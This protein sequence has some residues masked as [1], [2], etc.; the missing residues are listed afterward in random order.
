MEPVAMGTICI[1][2]AQIS[3]YT[4]K[5]FMNIVRKLLPLKAAK[6]YLYILIE[7]ILKHCPK[8]N[9]NFR[10]ITRNEEE[11]EICFARN[12]PQSIS[13]SSLHFLLQIYCISENRLP[14][15]QCSNNDESNGEAGGL[16]VIIPWTGF[17]I[18]A[19]NSQDRDSAT[20]QIIGYNRSTGSDQTHGGGGGIRW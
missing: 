7:D 8:R 17:P 16:I 1:W 9:P 20:R 5:S 15:G 12:I 10:D 19:Y 3:R 13:F 4:V 11:N 18:P 14:L 6:N 2:N